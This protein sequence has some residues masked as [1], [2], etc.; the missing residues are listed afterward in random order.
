MRNTGWLKM[1]DPF[2]YGSWSPG[3]LKAQESLLILAVWIIRYPHMGG[4]ER[5]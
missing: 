1:Q 4:K 2:L 5:G 3:P